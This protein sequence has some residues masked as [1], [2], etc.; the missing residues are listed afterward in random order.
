MN[1]KTAEKTERIKRADSMEESL[2]FIGRM[3][4]KGALF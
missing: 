1:G 4:M 3:A 2:V